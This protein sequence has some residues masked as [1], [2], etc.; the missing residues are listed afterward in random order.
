MMNY[1]QETKQRLK[2]G[3][4]ELLNCVL[5]LFLFLISEER[6]PLANI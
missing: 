1:K 6:Q 4:E 3:Q 5:L 2:W